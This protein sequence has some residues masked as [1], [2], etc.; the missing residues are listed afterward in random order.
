MGGGPVPRLGQA[1]WPPVV[2]GRRT[3]VVTWRGGAAGRRR[4]GG[5]AVRTIQAS[6][7]CRA[8]I[9]PSTTR[10]VIRARSVMTAH[11]PE[12]GRPS[13]GAAATAEGAQGEAG[14][15]PGR[16]DVHGQTHEV[17][18]EWP[19][20]RSE[21]ATLPHQVCSGRGPAAVDAD[22]AAVDVTQLSGE[23]PG[24]EDS[25]RHDDEPVHPQGPLHAARA[26][27]RRPERPGDRHMGVCAGRLTRHAVGDGR[28]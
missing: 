23:H 10:G 19:N 25:A 3:G 26:A 17:Q 21:A 8:Q 4:R 11:R 7:R 22:E 14:V 20:D 28:R 27:A 12:T 6:S 9:R 24:H 13:P 2:I 1:W 16:A 15:D 18:P 5:R